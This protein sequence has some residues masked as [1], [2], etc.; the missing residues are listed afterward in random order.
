MI[1]VSI[2][3]TDEKGKDIKNDI[4][5]NR[6]SKY[7]AKGYS[8]HE[9]QRLKSIGVRTAQDKNDYSNGTPRERTAQ[10]QRDYSHGTTSAYSNKD[11]IPDQPTSK[12]SYQPT[13]AELEHEKRKLA[14]YKPTS[15]G[16]NTKDDIDDGSKP[17]TTS[18]IPPVKEKGFLD[19]AGEYISGVGKQAGEFYGKNSG[20]INTGL[21]TAALG[22][23]GYAAYKK[24]KNDRAAKKANAKM[25]A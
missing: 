18:T 14:N 7:D 11:N 13:Q 2:K 12:S 20:V 17:S 8:T 1:E 25:M 6:Q 3:I 10:D 9:D 5:N 16:F 19:K 4:A 23:L 22:G 24:L 15:K 21:A